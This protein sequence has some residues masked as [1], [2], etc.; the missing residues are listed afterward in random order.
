MGNCLLPHARG[1]EIDSPGKKKN[2]NPQWYARVGGGGG[3]GGRGM[4][5]GQ[6][7]PCITDTPLKRTPRVVP[8]LSLP[9]LVDSL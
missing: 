7:E 1:W 5:A 9:L 2:A 6:I 4:V 3:G 8:C